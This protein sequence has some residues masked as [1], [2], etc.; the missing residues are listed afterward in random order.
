MNKSM[1]NW[2]DKEENRNLSANKKFHVGETLWEMFS[3]GNSRKGKATAK[4][5]KIP[6]N[7]AF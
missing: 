4:N 6:L 1:I 5:N 3:E 7:F 2:A